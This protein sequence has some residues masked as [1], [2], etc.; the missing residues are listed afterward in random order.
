MGNTGEVDTL[1]AIYAATLESV[2][3]DG[4]TTLAVE[5]Q[6]DILM[7]QRRRQEHQANPT[8]TPVL[9]EDALELGERSRALE[10]A[11]QK[12]RQTAKEVTLANVPDYVTQDVADQDDSDAYMYRLH[13]FATEN[14]QPDRRVVLENINFSWE[15]DAREAVQ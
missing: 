9:P 4:T 15:W 14:A 13:G 6:I 8:T 2:S 7:L 5:G 1:N 10:E 11:H 12:Q 3:D